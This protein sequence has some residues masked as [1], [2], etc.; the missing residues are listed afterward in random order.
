MKSRQRTSNLLL[1]ALIHCSR[2]HRT[3]HCWNKSAAQDWE[4]GGP[5]I[6]RRQKVFGKYAI[7]LDG[8]C[9]PR[10]EGGSARVALLDGVYAC[11]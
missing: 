7:E 1:T 8:V 11:V 4:T 9:E 10:I 3:A 2:S 6:Y 5:E